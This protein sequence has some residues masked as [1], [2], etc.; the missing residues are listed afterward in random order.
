MKFFQLEIDGLVLCEL[1][2]F[3]DERGHFCELYS[4]KRYQE[5]GIN[6]EFVQDNYSYSQAGVLRGLHYQ[7]NQ[8]QD[9]LVSCLKGEILDVAVD[10]R[11]NSKTFGKWISEK[12][13]QKNRRQLFIPK[14]FAHGFYVLS[15]DAIV[16]YKCSDFYSPKDDRGVLWN[17]PELEINWEAV[18][19]N[20][21]PKD[22]NLPRLKDIKL[23]DLPK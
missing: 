8:E 5:N 10:I 14:G 16:T 11:P 15:S 7:V 13:S 3:E 18:A 12:L 17:D 22:L 20:I 1:D 4:S 21:S 19:P 2:S 9:K 23:S 6:V